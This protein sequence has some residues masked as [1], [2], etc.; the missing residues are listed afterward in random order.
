MDI[1]R[2]VVGLDGSEHSQRAAEW[3]ASLATSID[4][5]VVGVHALGLLHRTPGGEL[6]PSDTHR[7]EIRDQL[8]TSWCAPFRAASVAYRAEL[9]EGNPVT[10]MLELADDVDADLLV[11]GSRGVGGFPGLLLGSTSTQVAQH[12]RRP[13]V[14]VPEPKR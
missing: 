4:A 13:V 11:V 2:I 3:A 1:R 10:T 7:D 8:E 9:R 5:E 12:A 14:I 6:V